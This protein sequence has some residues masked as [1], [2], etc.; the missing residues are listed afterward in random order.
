MKPSQLL[1]IALCLVSLVM[2]LPINLPVPGILPVKPLD[3]SLYQLQ[4]QVKTALAG[5]TA[6]QDAKI[7]EGVLRS[8][9][10]LFVLDAQRPA[11]YYK[12]GEDLKWAIRSIGDISY[13]LGWKMS[14][15]YPSLPGILSSHM[16]S[17]LGK[18][19]VKDRESLVKELRNV[20]DVLATI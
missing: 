9:A 5:P 12:N 17:R 20:A 6:D 11:P 1:G 8:S 3:P 16:E 13:P 18:D 15:R 14:E 4:A 2:V 19:E 10:N 7:L